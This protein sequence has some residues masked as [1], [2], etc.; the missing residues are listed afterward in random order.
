M[1]KKDAQI[2]QRLAYKIIHDHRY[3]YYD[4]LKKNLLKNREEIVIEQQCLLQNLIKYAYEHSI[5]YKEIMDFNGISPLDIKT[6]EDLKIFPVLTKK[7]I[8]ENLDKIKS[9]DSFSE[10]MIRVTSG[11]SSGNQA[12]IYK[13]KYFEQISRASW[14]RNNLIVGWYPSDKSVWFWGS[15]IEHA[16]IKNSILPKI[17]MIVNSR[18]VF[19]TYDYSPNDFNIWVKK[20]L[21]YKPK[22][23]YGYSSVIY[24]FSK[25]LNKHSIQL[26]SVS[27]VVSTTEQLTNRDYIKNAF[28]CDVYDQYGC[29]EVLAIGIE[30]QEDRLHITDDVVILNINNNNEFLVTALYSYGFPLINYKLGDKGSYN[31]IEN[32]P[33]IPFP[34]LD[35]KIGRITDNFLRVDGR[36]ISSS[37]LAT[38]ISSYDLGI[39]EYQINQEYY[40][41][42]NIKILPYKYTN[43]NYIKEIIVKCLN[44]YFGIN[45]RC[46]FNIV[47]KIEP[48]KSGKKLMY[49]RTFNID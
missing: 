14:L 5:Y 16:K 24:E 45:I 46:N 32:L 3:M 15:P 12:I 36:Y 48:E 27:K 30:S 41:L 7:G 28:G 1:K 37:A 2:R 38:Y 33:D 19:N 10:G 21:K 22:V 42:F 34:I 25:Y 43:V 6:S 40:D 13:S 39:K 31:Y 17:G 8:R 20:I 35:L 4:M 47:D 44:E 49:K 9:I 23:I 18:L 26:S 11:G 29:R